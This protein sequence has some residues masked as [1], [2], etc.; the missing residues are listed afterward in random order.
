MSLITPFRNAGSTEYLPEGALCSDQGKQPSS[1]RCIAWPWCIRCVQGRAEHSR[2]QGKG[3]MGFRIPGCMKHLCR[4]FWSC[5]W[6]YVIC[7][8]GPFCSDASGAG[9]HGDFR[10]FPPKVTTAA[11]KLVQGGHVWGLGVGFQGAFRWLN[12]SELRTNNTAS[13]EGGKKTI[14]SAGNSRTYSPPHKLRR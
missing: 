12:G 13:I 4:A 8:D 5:N 14:I 1:W 7:Q 10:A 3:M 11:T 2:V 9:L 6:G